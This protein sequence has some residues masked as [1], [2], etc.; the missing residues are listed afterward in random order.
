MIA[1]LV[2]AAVFSTEDQLPFY[3]IG[4]LV[5]PIAQKYKVKEVY[6]FGSYARGSEEKC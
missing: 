5:K 6:L 4:N 2:M 1:Y 3:T